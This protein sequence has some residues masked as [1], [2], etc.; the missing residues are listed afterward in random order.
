MQ[1]KVQQAKDADIPIVA[2]MV[3]ELLS[4]IMTTIGVAAFQ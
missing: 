3:G 2:T 1:V 4:E